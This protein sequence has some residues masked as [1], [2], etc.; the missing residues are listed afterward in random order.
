[1]AA[2]AYQ[3]K[4]KFEGL[5]GG[6]NV[7]QGAIANRFTCDQC[8][9][10]CTTKAHF[11]RHQQTHTGVKP[12]AC[13]QCDYRCTQKVH[14]ITHQRTHSGDKPFAC[15]QCDYRCAQ[16]G[17][18][19]KHLQ[20]HSGE[21]PFACDQCDYRTCDSTNL[22]R[23][24]QTHSFVAVAADDHAAP[25]RHSVGAVDSQARSAIPATPAVADEILSGPVTCYLCHRVV[26]KPP[27]VCRH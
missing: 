5:H 3:V 8:G 14:L 17:N 21:K 7:D 1:M 2:A 12:F 26:W 27:F 22:R 9:Y 23:H 15:D 18:L 11:Q 10:S 6:S 20:I 13:D 19:R 16:M 24:K 25:Q 4:R